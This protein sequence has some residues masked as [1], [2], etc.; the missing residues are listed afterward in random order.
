MCVCVHEC[1]GWK[2]STWWPRTSGRPVSITE[3]AVLGLGMQDGVLLLPLPPHPPHTVLDEPGCP[4]LQ[5]PGFS[6]VFIFQAERTLVI[7]KPFCV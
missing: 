7:P 4:E 1:H 6:S 2:R 3:A 5:L